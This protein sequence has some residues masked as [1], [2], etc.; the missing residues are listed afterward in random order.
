MQGVDGLLV[1]MEILTPW[2][3]LIPTLCVGTAMHI[4]VNR[5]SGKF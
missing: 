1:E 5:M 2:E 4:L 3:A